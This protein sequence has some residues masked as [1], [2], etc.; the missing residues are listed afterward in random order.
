MSASLRR[1]LMTADAVG[2]VWTYSLGLAAGLA[3]AGLDVELAVMGPP[4]DAQQRREAAAIPR[5]K[6]HMSPLKL[7]WMADAAGD[8]ARAGAW[9]LELAARAR[10]DLVHLNGYAHAALPF[11]A[12][13]LLVAHSCV[14]SWW[15]AVHGQDPPPAW[16][17]Y[18]S[19]VA[20]GLQAADHV[21]APSAAMLA[22]LV[23]CYG[24][25]RAPASVIPNGLP[26]LA[27]GASPKRE[28]VLAAGRVWDPAKNIDALVRAAPALAWP[29]WIAGDRA[30]GDRQAGDCPGVTML[31]RLD[32]RAMADAYAAAAIYAL[33]ARYEP[34]GLS[35]L[36][37]AQHG[38][39]LVLG[40]IPS[41]RENWD[42]AALFVDPTDAQSLLVVLSRLMANP[43]A[44][45]ELGGR[46]RA[47]ADRFP[48]ART[49]AAVLDLYVRLT[50]APAALPDG[51]PTQKEIRACAS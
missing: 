30:P 29:I 37:A 14:R 45:A 51:G 9:L 18:T 22:A 39:A 1:V 6:L 8:V 40:D 38:C 16:A 26:P 41:L 24:P 47:R 44:R 46:A 23:D 48:L 34:F 13:K 25:L 3:A 27:R 11:A 28:V 2:G 49:V 10:P 50:G 20:A 43:T 36:E 35:I 32:A 33:P 7:E 5:L 31:G 4:P 21:V 42:G 15:R 19:A 12:P 17:A